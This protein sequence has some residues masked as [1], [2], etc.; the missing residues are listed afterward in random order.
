MHPLEQDIC[1]QAATT[2]SMDSQISE[3][4]FQE[5]K[6]DEHSKSSKE[7][8][9]T[10]S[11]QASQESN[12][13]VPEASNN[14]E[15]NGDDD[16]DSNGHLGGTKH[17]FSVT[18]ETNGMIIPPVKPKS[19]FLAKSIVQNEEERLIST[20]NSWRQTKEEVLQYKVQGSLKEKIKDGLKE[21]SAGEKELTILEVIQGCPSVPDSSP[22]QVNEQEV[23]PL[24]IT[25][26][27]VQSRAVASLPSSYL[28][29]Q[30]VENNK[31]AVFASRVI[32]ASC[33]FG[34]M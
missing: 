14:A 4:S 10:S 25:D 13:S 20:E 17:I 6:S 11:Q 30:T 21:K 23:A 18:T 33:R 8:E 29:L 1:N 32:P 3:K 24:T 5:N 16:E 7:T 2:G 9:E 12:A 28:S 22:M 27:P 26:Q 31:K 19:I 34:P 15:L